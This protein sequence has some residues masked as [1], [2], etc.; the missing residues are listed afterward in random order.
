MLLGTSYDVA[1]NKIRLGFHFL[2]RMLESAFILFLRRPGSISLLGSR[3]NVDYVNLYD[4]KTTSLLHSAH[5]ESRCDP[6]LTAR[7]L[8]WHSASISFLTR[9]NGSFYVSM[10][11]VPRVDSVIKVKNSFFLGSSGIKRTGTLFYQMQFSYSSIM[12]YLKFI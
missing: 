12:P 5:F 1:G 11:Q 10:F 8:P 9:A 6:R 2:P 3:I 7:R 4:V